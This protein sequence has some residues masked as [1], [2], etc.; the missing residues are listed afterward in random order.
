MVTARVLPP[1]GAFTVTVVETWA[2]ATLDVDSELRES[3]GA[4][5]LDSV[6]VHEDSTKRNVPTNTRLARIDPLSI[7]VFFMGIE[8]NVLF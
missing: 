8:L 7:V 3:V 4:G 5:L 2:P 1:S 6:F